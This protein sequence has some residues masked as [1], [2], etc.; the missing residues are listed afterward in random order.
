MQTTFRQGIISYPRS[1]PLQQFLSYNSQYVSLNTANGV[2]NVAFAHKTTDYLLT[3]SVDVANAWGPIPLDTNAWLFW[4]INLRTGERTF[5]FTTVEP[6]VSGTQPTAV[7]DQHWFDLNTTT[8]YVYNGLNWITVA[9]VFAARINNST[10]APL[11]IGIANL[12]YAGTQV[13]LNVQALVGR[14]AFDSDGRPIRKSDGTLFTTEDQ[15]FVEGSPVSTLRLESTVL[16]ARAMQTMA[17]YQIVRF[18]NFGEVSLA[19]YNDIQ[20]TAI[21]ISLENLNT[22]DIGSLAIQGVVTN[23]TWN[24]TTVGAPLWVNTVGE[25]TETDPHTVDVLTHPIGKPPIARVLSSTSIF[26]DQGLGGN[27]MQG[28]GSGP[29]LEFASNTTYG[30]TLLSVAPATSNVPVA[31]GDN[32]PRMTNAR[33]PTAH[34]HPA[35]QVIVV[36]SGNVTSVDAQSAIEQLDLIK[37]NRSGSTMTGPLT[38]SADPTLALHAATKQYVDATIGGAGATGATGPAGSAGPVGATGFTGPTG[39]TGATGPQ[40]PAGSSADTGDFTFVNSQMS[41]PPGDVILIQSLDSDDTTRSRLRLDADSGSATLDATSDTN[42]Q[43]FDD[44]HWAQTNWQASTAGSGFIEF[45]DAPDIIDFLETTLNRATRIAFSINGE[46]PISYSGYGIDGNV[47]TLGTG[48]VQPSEPVSVDNI[49][50]F[51]SH[52]SSVAVNYDDGSISV[53][54][55]N[56]NIDITTD[57]NIDIDAGQNL[58]LTG[59]EVVQL[60]NKSNTTPLTIQTNDLQSTNTWLFGTDGKIT[61]PPGGDILD[62]NGV[63]V[64]SNDEEEPPYRGFYVGLNRVYGEETSVNQLIFSN[65]TAVPTYGNIT[66]DTDNDDF[67]AQ[68]LDGTT[69]VMLNLYGSSTVVPLDL[70]ALR[71]FAELFIDTVLYDGETPVQSA[72]VAQTR[73]DDNFATVIAPVSAELLADGLFQFFEANT[74]FSVVGPVTGGTGSG[75]SINGLIYDMSNDTINPGSWGNNQPGGYTLGDTLTILGTDIRD[76]NGNPLSSPENDLTV[77]ITQIAGAGFVDAFTITGTIPRPA[78]TWP[79]NFISDGYS[80]IYDDGNYINTNLSQEIPYFGGLVATDTDSADHWGVGSQY[81]TYYNNSVWAIMAFDTTV[82]TVNYSGGSG[83][84]GNGIKEAQSLIGGGGDSGVNLGNFVFSQNTMT[85]SDPNSDLTIIS[86]DDLLL[87][88]RGDDVFIRSDDDIRLQPGYNFQDDTFIWTAIFRDDGRLQ[89]INDDNGDTYGTIRPVDVDTR[90]VLEVGSP[91]VIQ[92]S[93]NNGNHIWMFDQNGRLNIP[94]NSGFISNDNNSGLTVSAVNNISLEAGSAVGNTAGNVTLTGGASSNGGSAGRV[95]LAA[96]TGIGAAAGIITITGGVT[97]TEEPNGGVVR[98]TGGTVVAS[99]SA[100]SGNIEL[101][102][103]NAITVGLDDITPVRF[104]FPL[105]GTTDSGTPTGPLLTGDGLTISIQSIA[106]MIAGNSFQLFHVKA[107]VTGI[108]ESNSDGA[109][110]TVEG[111]IRRANNI[112]TFVA[113]PITTVVYET[114][115]AWDATLTVDDV[116]EQLIVQVTGGLAT[117]RWN[118]IVEVQPIGTNAA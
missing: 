69:V 53:L 45:I 95:V 80:D 107:T 105:A 47:L 51:F 72:A 68:G 34:T 93:S 36:P 79:F 89:F 3:E 64:L 55:N 96:G 6:V 75:F 48:S 1:G 40:G 56:I 116:T 5:G 46:D 66:N 65:S 37:M 16:T 103:R 42:E 108:S 78:E 104:T 24:W 115:A 9:R 59:D 8:M 91:D 15:F 39:L 43:M 50:F 32:D 29:L 44:T 62:S 97:T 77:T 117:V 49:T 31:V 19:S 18:S 81:V 98:V 118:A 114:D 102:T 4:D 21:A 20:T 58:T 7:T 74:W 25:L 26:F 100:R 13:G 71:T 86:G 113:G 38:L 112:P 90:R 82:N 11:G 73:F 28:P 101:L 23:P 111:V 27:N 14:I 35:T 17:A 87:E 67:R 92:I 41:A 61:L 84:D 88:A 12:P 33:P 30:I 76:G 110:Y 2:T 70:V 54:G 63:S 60:W 85:I 22:D 52:R 109:V 94:G 83:F 106:N 99:Q 10:F 57:R